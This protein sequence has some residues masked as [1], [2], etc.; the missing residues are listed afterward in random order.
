MPMTGMPDGLRQR[1]AEV[2]RHA[3]DDEHRR[4]PRRRARGRPRAALRP[5]P[6]TSPGR[7]SRRACE[8]IAA[9]GRRGR[10]PGCRAA[11]RNSTV[12]ASHAP[13]S[14]FTMCGAGLERSRPRGV[15]G[16]G[17]PPDSCR[18]AGRRSRARVARPA[19]TQRVWYSTS[20][21]LT[22][23]VEARPWTTMPS[24]SPTSSTSTP[25]R[26][27][28]AGERRV[29]G[30]QHRDLPPVG[31]HAREHRERHRRRLAGG[32]GRSGRARSSSRCEIE[33]FAAAAHRADAREQEL[34]VLVVVDE[35]EPLAVH[36]QER[37]RLVRVEVAAVRIGEA[38]RGTAPKSCARSRR[39]AGARAR[40][41]CRRAPAGRRRGPAW[42]SA[43]SGAN[44]P[45]RR[46]GT[47]RRTG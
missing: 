18:T 41:A 9:A 42:A 11:A 44:R 40:S 19:A 47:R 43:A 35:V 34:D 22:D 46:A 1:R 37:R 29:V 7:D 32:A 25:A 6:A 45:S 17:R 28:A 10:R 5:R 20:S 36:D 21:R 4:R 38:R 23:S 2:P 8:P 31:R 16:L 39:R 3:F 24:E 26:S 15:R 13:P 14:S 27:A 33:E 12:G 30:G